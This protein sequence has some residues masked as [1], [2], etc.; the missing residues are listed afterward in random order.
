MALVSKPPS[1]I[2]ITGASR[3]LGRALA[4]EY[5]GPGRVLGLAGRRDDLLRGVAREC[6]ERG[7]RV[8]PAVFDVADRAATRHW[9]ER[10]HGESPIDLLIVNAGCF[11]G[12]GAHGAFEPLD[13]ALR[14]VRTNLMGAITTVDTAVPLMRARRSGQIAIIASLAALQPLADAP[15][16]SASKAGLAGYGEALR[17]LLAPDGIRVS[18]VY[19][20]HIDTEQTA[21]HVGRLPMIIAPERAASRIR[22][23]L[24][25]RR[26]S[27]AFPL[28]LTCVIGLGRLLPWRLRAVLG[29]PLR[30]HVD[31]DV[32][33]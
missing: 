26:G 24:A 25:W 29:R 17:E 3:G 31:G 1:T 13:S 8:V 21:H 20:G 9:M 23:G 28:P 6:E 12:N 16:Y 33:F 14:Q 22:R 19:P 7:A 18:L 2:L 11:H 4:L 32:R 15:A 27:I 30:F 10:V 5:A